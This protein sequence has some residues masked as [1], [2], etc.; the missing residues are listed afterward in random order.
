MRSLASDTS[1][2][3]PY[4]LRSGGISTLLSHPPQAS[5]SQLSKRAGTHRYRNP[6]TDPRLQRSEGCRRSAVRIEALNRRSQYEIYSVCALNQSFHDPL[7]TRLPI[8]NKCTDYHFVGGI[9]MAA[10]ETPIATNANVPT[11]TTMTWDRLNV[12]LNMVIF[13]L[14]K[15][16]SPSPS[17]GRSPARRGAAGSSLSF[18]RDILRWRSP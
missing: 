2:I 16:S 17:P 11:T 5:W 4:R 18:G 1:S 9:P 3:V 7:Q 6:R 15:T 8:M 12:R 14:P 13:L 10:I